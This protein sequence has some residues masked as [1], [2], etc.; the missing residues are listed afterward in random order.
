MAADVPTHLLNTM[1][2]ADAWATHPMMMVM[3]MI[4]VIMMVMMVV[5]MMMMIRLFYLSVITLPPYNSHANP[6]AFSRQRFTPP[7]A[8]EPTR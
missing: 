1:G 7:K 8:T 4:M 2:M 6:G 5:M 3:M